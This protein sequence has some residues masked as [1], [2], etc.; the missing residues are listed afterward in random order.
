MFPKDFRC[1]NEHVRINVDIGITYEPN[2]PAQLS[3]R[4]ARDDNQIRDEVVL[5]Q[6]IKTFIEQLELPFIF[7]QQAAKDNSSTQA[8]EASDLPPQYQAHEKA[9]EARF[10]E[11]AVKAHSIIAPKLKLAPAEN[12]NDI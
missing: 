1:E 2:K 3:Y 8:E 10:D 5:I 12:S 7:L 9:A 4:V 6:Q 11:Y